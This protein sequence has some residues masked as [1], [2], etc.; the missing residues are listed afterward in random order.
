[1]SA[2]KQVPLR[3]SPKLWE[4][5]SK[6]ADD[7]FRSINGQIEYVLHQAVQKRLGGGEASDSDAKNNTEDEDL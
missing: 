5:L 7:E 1:M 4:E 6:W 2:K 3:L